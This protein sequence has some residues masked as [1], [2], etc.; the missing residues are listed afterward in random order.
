MNG[1][2]V[3]ALGATLAFMEAMDETTLLQSGQT[4]V[5]ARVRKAFGASAGDRIVWEPMR[6]G[7]FRVRIEPRKGLRGLVGAAKGLKMDAV[8]AKKQAQRGGR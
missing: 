6:D 1:R 2:K 3:K 7:S 4:Q 8:A 5:P